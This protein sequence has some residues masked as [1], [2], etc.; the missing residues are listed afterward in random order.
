MRTDTEKLPDWGRISAPVYRNVCLSES[1][2]LVIKTPH[3]S[4]CEKEMQIQTAYENT[5]VYAP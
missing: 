2:L 5:P 4:C 3:F 1:K